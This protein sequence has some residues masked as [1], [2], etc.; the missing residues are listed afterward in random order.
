MS[1]ASSANIDKNQHLLNME[2]DEFDLLGFL[3]LLRSKIVYILL[4]FILGGTLSGL[5]TK[6]FITPTYTAVTKLYVVSASTDS[7]VN[8]S[9]LQIGSSLTADYEH[10]ILTRPILE[11]VITNLGLE[12]VY[13]T[14]SLKG[15]ITITNP[16]DSRMLYISIQTTNPQYSMDIANEIARQTVEQLGDLMDSTPPKIAEKAVYPEHKTSPSVTKNAMLGCIVF[17]ITYIGILLIRFLLDNKIDS[18]QDVEK[19]LGMP[20]IGIIPE[21]SKK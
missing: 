4:L 11:K 3:Y 7:L 21:L 2:D 15:T 18:E 16:Q 6:F 1:E 8:L 9:D 12:G 13:T 14:E 20:P 19:Y 5:Y 10:L 17:S